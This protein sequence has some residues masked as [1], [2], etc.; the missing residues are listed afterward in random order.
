MRLEMPSKL[1]V[2]SLRKTY[3]AVVALAGADLE[4]REGEFVTLLGPSG[5]GKSTFL[6][7][8]AGLVHPDSGDIWIGGRLSTF[9]APH[10]RDI[11]VVFQDYALFP[12][13]TIAE[14]IAFPLRMR[15]VSSDDTKRRVSDALAI[16]Q[17]SHA[18]DRLPAQLSG[19][20]QQRVALA[21]CM[22]YRPSIIL[23]DEPLGALDRRLREQMQIEIKRLH[24]EHGITVMY[25]THD[26]DEAL[27]M[28]D[29]ICLMN[30]GRIVQVG[31][32]ED[33]YLR[34]TSAFA[35]EFLGEA[36]M[37][38]GLVREVRGDRVHIDT[39]DGGFCSVNPAKAVPGQK[40]RMVVRPE[41]VDV[42]LKEQRAQNELSVTVTDVLF[43]GKVRKY[44]GRS[45]NGTVVMATTLARPGDHAVAVGDAV[46]FGWRDHD[47]VLAPGI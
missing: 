20:Q 21:R 14:N 26:Q 4:V 18:A 25:V 45:K 38:E 42:L 34:P 35:A 15:G 33:I 32:P 8:V 41:H 23:M 10:H 37:I 46:R 19:G 24:I 43:L 22:I 16:V 17:L 40:V 28:S 47:S 27:A 30:E 3:G 5:S 2:A 13:M 9:A 36:N 6:M 31:T 39:S 7:L 1:R 29:R 11:G 44:W 12:H